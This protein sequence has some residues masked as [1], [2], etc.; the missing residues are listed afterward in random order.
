MVSGGKWRLAPHLALLNRKLVD[1]AAGR[2]TRLLVLMPPRHGKSELCSKY[3]TSWYLGTFPER[4]VILASY[5]ANFAAK[6]GR[7]TRA[8]LDQWGPSIFGVTPSRRTTGGHAWELLEGGGMVT[9]GVRGPITGRGCH[10]LCLDDPVKNAQEAQSPTYRASTWDW[11]RSTAYT[12]LEPEG[13]ALVVLTH[14][15][16]DDVAG[17]IMADMKAG[18]EQWEVVKLAAI[19][20]PQDV[21]EDPLGREAG[22][23]LWPKRYSAK[24]L[25]EIKSVAGPYWWSALY[26]QRPYALEGN[27]LKRSWWK[28][29]R[30]N[31]LP[32]RFDR[33]I[34]SWDMTFKGLD[35]NDWVVGQLWG[36]FGPDL[37]LLD[38]VRGHW[39][40]V[41]TVQHFLMFTT[42]HPLA[43]GKLIEDKANGPAVISMLKKKVGGL[44]PMDPKKL[45]GSKLMRAL[46]AQPVIQAGNVWLPDPEEIP[47]VDDFL[48]EMSAFPT[49][50]HD[51]MVDA[52]TQA[53]LYLT[54]KSVSPAALLAVGG[55]DDEP[56][57]EPDDE[58]EEDEDD[59]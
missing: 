22:Q 37:Y 44:I 40:F 1:L 24:R 25:T 3:F 57:P 23:A 50:A 27:V 4:S 31:E 43:R 21:K 58:P 48:H 56:E 8:V 38:Q 49:G 6:W 20:E 33:L 54:L 16:E 46:A 32:R 35:E 52:C 41:Q 47:W 2:I 28:F 26:Q 42:N 7:D 12:R 34:Q 11:W 59:E 19:C 53:L 30:H 51:D 17:R 29:Y 5:E 39:D 13:S 55:P 18:G 15:H 10:L 9:T 45:G 36:K 14:W